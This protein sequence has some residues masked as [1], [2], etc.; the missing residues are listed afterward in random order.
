MLAAAGRLLAG[1][2]CAD[3]QHDVGKLRA[4]ASTS[5]GWSVF[6]RD[7]TPHGELL[8][9]GFAH[10]IVQWP[11][12]RQ[13]LVCPE[14]FPAYTWEDGEHEGLWSLL[15]SGDQLLTL[16]FGDTQPY[17]ELHQAFCTSPFSVVTH[18]CLSMMSFE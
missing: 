9:T 12:S 10:D 4:L 6:A 5:S 7:D 17:P 13:Q 3:L 18:L 1:P 15:S 2:A 16:L 14:R 11:V 8:A